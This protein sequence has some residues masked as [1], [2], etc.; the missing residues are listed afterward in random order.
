VVQRNWIIFSLD[1]EEK[2]SIRLRR[3]VHFHDEI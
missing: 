2:L 3:T 1:E